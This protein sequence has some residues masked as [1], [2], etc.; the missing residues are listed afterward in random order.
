MNRVKTTQMAVPVIMI[1]AGCC[2]ARASETQQALARLV[3]DGKVISTDVR[4]I[5]GRPYVSVA[6]VAKAL[7]T[8]VA[9][10]GGEYRL[11]RNG[12]S[13]QLKGV[14][15]K[16]ATPL[17]SGDWSLTVFSINQVADYTQQFGSVKELMLPQRSDDVL[18]VVKCQLKNATKTTQDVYFD[19]NSSGNTSLTDDQ[20]HSYSPSAFD[21]RN[22]NY[23]TSRMLP[24]SAHE[25]SLIFSVP[26][27][28]KF[29]DLIYTVD[30]SDTDSKTDFRVSLK[31]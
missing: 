5:S 25:F 29:R 3:L 31:P 4:V 18:F 21:S 2:A 15:G 13:S 17:H 7:N 10:N 24:G 26:A 1:V 16:I 9:K 28:T 23:S 22:D 6:D 19:K 12:G 30:A 8:T 20:S 11:V 14:E 27:N